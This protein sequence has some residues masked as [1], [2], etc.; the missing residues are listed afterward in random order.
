M[1]LLAAI[2]QKREIKTLWAQIGKNIWTYYAASLMNFFS[3]DTRLLR[4]DVDAISV[5]T[6]Y[7]ISLKR[8][9]KTSRFDVI[10]IEERLGKRKSK[11]DVLI[12]SE[13]FWNFNEPNKE[14]NK[15]RTDKNF[16]NYIKFAFLY[17]YI[18]IFLPDGTF[19]FFSLLSA[20]VKKPAWILLKDA[21]FLFWWEKIFQQLEIV[22][23]MVFRN[24]SRK[25]PILGIFLEFNSAIVIWNIHDRIK[26]ISSLIADKFHRRDIS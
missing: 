24:S 23:K 4:F 16:F 18:F 5:T 20:P 13:L 17:I 9:I 1:I 10:L 8:L 15:E 3:S 21:Q 7:C 11:R 22:L 26:K 12:S 14:G 25:R 2:K 6:Q 19:N